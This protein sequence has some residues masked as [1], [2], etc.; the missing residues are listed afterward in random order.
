MALHAS[1]KF[2]PTEV[3]ILDVTCRAIARYGARKINLT[4]IAELAG[5]SRT[6]LYRHFPAKDHLLLAVADYEMEFY[7]AVFITEL[8]GLR[9]LERLEQSLR[10]LADFDRPALAGLV[11]Q[12]PAFVLDQLPYSLRVMAATLVPV[13]LEVADELG[14]DVDTVDDLAD[15]TVRTALSHLLIESTKESQLLWELRHIC[16]LT[17]LRGRQAQAGSQ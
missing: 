14:L 13:F 11:P 7:E 16:G 15:L 12:E 2:S 5:V 3:Q 4:E 6:T 9:G 8:A 17:P 1:T 10:I